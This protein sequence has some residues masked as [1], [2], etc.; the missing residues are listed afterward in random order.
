MAEEKIPV[1][2][3]ALEA[4]AGGEDEAGKGFAQTPACPKCGG[5]DVML[6]DF[7]DRSFWHCYD[8]GYDWGFSS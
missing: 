5:T 3:E 7:P 6:E 4:V 1:P 8:C 2:D